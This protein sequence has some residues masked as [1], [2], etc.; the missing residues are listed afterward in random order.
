MEDEPELATLL[1]EVLISHD[2]TR[3]T[4]GFRALTNT[5]WWDASDFDV[6]FVDLMLS[7]PVRGEDILKA[8]D[9]AL[10]RPKLIAATAKPTWEL[11]EAMTYADVICPKPYGVA[12]ILD[13]VKDRD[14]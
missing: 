3:V 8:A 14:R 5:A 13:L 4:H 10:R 6:A 1:A 9:S 7:D 12:A 11:D 2:V